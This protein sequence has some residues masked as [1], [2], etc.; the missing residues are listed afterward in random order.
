[1]TSKNLIAAIV[2]ACGAAGAALAAPTVICGSGATL[3]TNFFTSPAAS[4]DFLGTWDG[5]ANAGVFGSLFPDQLAPAGDI[6]APFAAGTEWQLH[7]R[8]NGSGNGISELDHFASIFDK[9]PDNTDDDSDTMVNDDLGNSSYTDNAVY[10]RND[11]VIAGVLQGIGIATNRSGTISVPDGA[12][13][14]AAIAQT[15][16]LTNGFTVDFNTADVS[17][18]WFAT[19]AGTPRPD[20]TPGSSGYGAN[21]IIATDKN[22]VTLSTNNQLKPLA[23][24]N[25]NVAAPNALTVWSTAVSMAPVA[26]LVNFGV[27]EDTIYMS[28][29]RHLNATGR[30]LVG[31][32]L[33]CCTRDSG[34]GTRNAF[35]NGIGLDPSWGRGENIGNRT[36]SSANDRV[37][38]DYQPSNKGGSSR[39]DATVQNTRLGTG[40]T[41]AERLENDG[42]FLDE[43]MDCFNV[44]ADIK[45]GTVAARP[46]T[47]E[48][49]DGGPDGFNIIAASSFSH[50]GDPRNAPAADGGW[51]WRNL[52]AVV[53]ALGA[54]APADDESGPNPFAGN[55]ACPNP[56]TNRFINNIRRSVKEFIAFPGGPTSDFMPGEFLALNFLLT[57]APDNV[58]ELD[59][60]TATQPILIVG[61]GDQNLAVRAATAGSSVYNA[62]GFVSFNTGTAGRAPFRTTGVVYSD[63]VAGGTSYLAQS[64][65]SV[66]YGSLLSLRNKVCGDFNGDGA[67]SAADAADMLAAFDQRNGG[68]AWS[69]PD[70]IY[71]SGAGATAII[72]VL[73]D[74]NADGNFDE[75]DI[76][77]WADG[78]VL[79]DN[80]LDVVP[81][82]PGG[83]GDGS[84]DATL[85]RAAGFAA[86]DTAF[87]GNFFGTTLANGTY[88]TGDSRADVAGSGGQTP[89]WAPIGADGTVDDL[90]IDYVCA[91][92]GDWQDLTVAA[93]MDLSC[94]MNGD[95]VV[96]A[97][98][99]R[100][101]VEDV[102]ETNFGDV[103]L[104]GVVDGTDEAIVMANQGMMN[105]GWA[106]GDTD[107]DGDVDADDLLVFGAA[108]TCDIDGSG[109]LNLDDV[110]LFAQG[111]IGGNLAVDQ[112][113]NGVLN[114]DDVNLFAACFIAGCP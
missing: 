18:A 61:N 79:V 36:S 1:M 92:F 75:D 43:D 49:L 84:T 107:C 39:M 45:G 77:Y 73:G 104:D 14:Y 30:R 5:D 37:G 4:N 2:A 63:G 58:P 80:G 46:T 12:A 47:A 34:S 102:L 32:N 68:S 85:D 89:G 7:Y 100:V 69:A 81:V 15:A 70:G 19:Q 74:Y 64:G 51:G 26:P 82:T 72:E 83:I 50:R 54:P 66:A 78:L 53:T 57:A 65:A 88:S 23:V 28:D 22:G 21:P 56:G 9:M 113:G 99:V 105:A 95:L 25:T 8:L 52:P 110:N 112:D 3:Y 6:T 108:C 67:R 41:G 48:I 96:D 40:H 31:E 90:D 10:N 42:Y 38:P 114:L 62:P 27:G 33:I 109:G 44:I 35:M 111:F 101:I 60:T 11:L 93:G 55:P 16:A 98:D 87:G 86:V 71:G 20:A 59:P 17:L 103:N 24:L 106:D 13:G 97:E 76:R 91:N 29:L 94:D